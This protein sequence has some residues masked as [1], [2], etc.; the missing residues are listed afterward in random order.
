MQS[1][2]R[3]RAGAGKL[4]AYYSGQRRN[5]SLAGCCFTPSA[6]GLRPGY[7][8]IKEGAAHVYAPFTLNVPAKFVMFNVTHTVIEIESQ[9][10][11]REIGD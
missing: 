1:K 11:N 2:L 6:V 5:V 10:V 8:H 7:I 4:Q 9:I 3:F